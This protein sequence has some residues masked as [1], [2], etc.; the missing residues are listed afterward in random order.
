MYVYIY[1]YIYIYTCSSQYRHAGRAKE[2]KA[3]GTAVY[4]ACRRSLS[5]CRRFVSPTRVGQ[6]LLIVEATRSHSYTP[7]SVG[8]LWMS[9]QFVAEMST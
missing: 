8:L 4:A 7:H 6:G 5:V 3:I 1:I 2:I 9:D